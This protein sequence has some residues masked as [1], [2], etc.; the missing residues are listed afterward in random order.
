MKSGMGFV[1]GH[2]AY[3]TEHPVHAILYVNK[4]KNLQR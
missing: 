3:V 1:V 4:Q 2:A